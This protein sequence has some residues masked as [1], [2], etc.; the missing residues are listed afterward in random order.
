MFIFI[1]RWFPKSPHH[2]RS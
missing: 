1:F 2:R